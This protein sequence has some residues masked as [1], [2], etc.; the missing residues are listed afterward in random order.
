MV[1]TAASYTLQAARR[2]GNGKQR[3][4]NSELKTGLQ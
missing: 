3:T 4:E 1:K 2:R